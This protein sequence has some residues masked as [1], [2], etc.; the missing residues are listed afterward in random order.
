MKVLTFLE[1]P[2]PKGKLVGISV[3]GLRMGGCSFVFPDGMVD[4]LK[5]TKYAS[6]IAKCEDLVAKPYNG[7]PLH[8]KT[9]LMV[10]A[11]GYGDLLFLTP[12]I[13]KLKRLYP[14][15]RIAFAT[16]GDNTMVFSGNPDI[17]RY[18][19]YPIPLPA[20]ESADFHILF[21]NTLEMSKDPELHAVDLFA[22]HA[23]VSLNFDEKIPIYSPSP[24]RVEAVRLRLIE[25]GIRPDVP[26]IA[27]QP[28]A[29]SPIRTYPEHLMAK[30]IEKLVHCGNAVLVLGKKGNF[31]KKARQG[32][33]FDLCGA[34]D[35]MADSVAALA[36]CRA[37]VA[38]DSSLTHFAAAIGIPTVALYGPFPGAVRTKYYPR[39]VTLEAKADCV[40]CMLHGHKPCP[41]AQK[42]SQV[43]SPCFESVSPKA[44]VEQVMNLRMQNEQKTA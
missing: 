10:R 12:L 34:F 24:A 6:Y 35:G 27:V 13:R 5:K 28:A 26:W 2:D 20:F 40:P 11:G 37:L 44:V 23:H 31:P 14:S 1:K 36:S 38:P 32:G 22:A 19:S 33:V 15:C 3:N 18:Y 25:K 17:L 8:G 7:E 29:S 21:E 4:H 42:L 30:V 39:C 9:I 43:W 41:E 16:M